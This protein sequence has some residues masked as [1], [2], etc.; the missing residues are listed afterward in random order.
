MEPMARTRPI[1]IRLDAAT[2]AR[3][4]RLAA[5]MSRRAQGA[6]VTRAAALRRAIELGLAQLEKKVRG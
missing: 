2:I 6:Q 4:D 1:P 3:A 5:A